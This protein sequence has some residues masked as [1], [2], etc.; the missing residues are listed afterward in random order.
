MPAMDDQRRST[1][2]ARRVTLARAQ[3]LAGVAFDSADLTLLRRVVEEV[4]WIE[5]VGPTKVLHTG[6]L[7]EQP[8]TIPQSD[9]QTALRGVVRLVAD[10]PRDSTPF[11][12]WQDRGS[13]LW[14]DT[15]STTL[16]CKV[17]V[18]TIGV[19]VRCDQHPQ[20]TR[21]E[22]PFGVGTEDRPAGLIMS[23]LTHLTGPEV[24]VERWGEAITAFAWESVVET[25]RRLCE[26]LDTDSRGRR[27]VPGGIAS[28]SK[29]L[30][31]Q[32][33]SALSGRISR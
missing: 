5:V 10:L 7:T 28:G 24:I 8:L 18:V 3:R 25:A 30:I 12:V 21:I 9:A 14:V 33:M 16:T 17:G 19:P 4:P 2:S 22:V 1:S 27:L 29:V 23:T 31:I 11:V 15:A 26:L 13:E 20:T 6:Q 32:P